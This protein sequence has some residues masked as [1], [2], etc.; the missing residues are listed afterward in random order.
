VQSEYKCVV[1]TAAADERSA[2]AGAG[3]D[4][5]AD[6]DGEH[7][8]LD[9]GQYQ[10]ELDGRELHRRPEV[11]QVGRDCLVDDRGAVHRQQR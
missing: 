10:H 3:R 2:R 1:L 11:Q 4:V 6:Q 5:V 8:A 7:E 9:V